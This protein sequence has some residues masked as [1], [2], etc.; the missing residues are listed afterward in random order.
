M[1]QQSAGGLKLLAV[2]R[3]VCPRCG[4]THAHRS[5]KKTPWDFV[6]GLVCVRVYR[7]ERCQRRHHG[8]KLLK[9][10]A[11]PVKPSGP[12]RG[13]RRAGLMHRYRSWRA[14]EGRHAG[15]LL[16]IAGMLSAA[17]GG[18]FFLLGNSSYLFGLA[19]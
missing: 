18:F 2:L 9:Q 10:F 14:R 1:T 8:W 19:G 15:R 6:L 3:A 17:V 12:R 16:L 5:P 4:S 7:C 11:L 13:W